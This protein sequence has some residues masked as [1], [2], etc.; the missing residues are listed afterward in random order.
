QPVVRSTV[1]SSAFPAQLHGLASFSGIVNGKL[2]APILSG[3]L[4]L[5]DFETATSLPE[6]STLSL[7]GSAAAKKPAQ[8]GEERVHWDSLV[9]D[10]S[11]SADSA[12]IKNMLLKHGRASISANATAG[13]VEGAPTHTSPL[14]LP[15]KSR[16][17]ELIE[18]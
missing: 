1:Y 9:G 14:A 3:H 6:G 10:I 15:R 2:N 17:G 8:T 18:V 4:Q 11:Y 7:P 5:S 13:V 12:A 16:A